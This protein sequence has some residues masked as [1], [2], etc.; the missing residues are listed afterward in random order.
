MTSSQLLA[1]LDELREEGWTVEAIDGEG[2]A[3][4]VFRCYSMPAGFSKRSTDLLLKLPI[5]YPNGQPDMFWVEVDLVLANGDVPK[6][7]NVV[8]TH[9]G[10][11][12]R[13]FSWHLKNWNPGRD[14]IRTY[15]E[16]VNARLAKAE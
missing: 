3:L 7:A 14:N 4:V 6:E 9:L 11:Q 13:R 12:W 1:E 8:E 16:F 2:S 5:S 15:L 10:R